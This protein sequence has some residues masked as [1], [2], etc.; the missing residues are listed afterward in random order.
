MKIT[1]VFCLS[2]VSALSSLG[3][4]EGAKHAATSEVADTP[5]M[6]ESRVMGVTAAQLML[7][8][9]KDNDKPEFPGIKSWL[10][11]EGKT[12]DALNKDKP[13][14]SWRKL[15]GD[16]LITHNASF[17]Q[18]FY[19]VVPGDPGLAML[20]AGTLM[21]AGD[22]DRALDILRLTLHRGDLDEDT[23]KIL[24]GILQHN[25]RFKAPSNEL[26]QAGITF[27]DKGDYAAAL[28]QYDAA[29]RLWPLNGWATYERGNTLRTRDGGTESKLSKQ[30]FADSR[31]AQPFQWAA[32]QGAVK[33]VPGMLNM[34]KVAR[35]LWEKS[36]KDIKYVM[37]REELGQM[38]EAL[39]EAQVDD[40]ALVTR[41][42]FIVRQGRYMPAD[43]PFIAKS[44]RRLVP[45]PQTEQTIKKLG[46]SKG[47][48][49]VQ[50]FV[51]PV[52][53][54]EQ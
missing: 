1:V 18:L 5:E 35:P 44:L 28:T 33:D 39:Q 2:L 8:R 22:A 41:Q 13:D 15:E 16:R 45:G 11:R 48:A 9:L 42:I 50:I 17:W 46:G 12:L 38:S 19:E 27:H 43:H 4:A 51:A 10:A 20:H 32:W 53:G 3:R 26:V 54:K 30:A 14:V 34:H 24:S 47:M 36:L 29:L 37:S 52:P 21:A 6:A 23:V 40:L 25:E 49:T 7:V 31:R